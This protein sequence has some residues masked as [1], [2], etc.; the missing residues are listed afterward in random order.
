[1]SLEPLLRS[2]GTR[3]LRHSHDMQR[4]ALAIC[5]CH[6]S[7]PCTSCMSPRAEKLQFFK[8][9]VLFSR[10]S[11]GGSIRFPRRVILSQYPKP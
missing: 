7:I 6:V 3:V 10:L 2:E 11:A 1:V 8:D 9:A 4:V 5:I